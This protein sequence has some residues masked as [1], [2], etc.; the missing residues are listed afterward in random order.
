MCISAF[1]ECTK[2]D[3][4]VKLKMLVKV[5]TNKYK[6]CLQDEKERSVRANLLISSSKADSK[7]NWEQAIIN[8][9]T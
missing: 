9:M 4:N 7:E 6:K 1:Q 3:R 5:N 8:K 2:H